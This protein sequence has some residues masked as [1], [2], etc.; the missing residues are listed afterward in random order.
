MYGENAAAEG[1][2]AFEAWLGEGSR[3]TRRAPGARRDRAV[4]VRLRPRGRPTRTSP[5]S[6]RCSRRPSRGM[7]A[8]RDAGPEVR[9]ASAWRCWP[10]CTRASSSWPTPCSTPA[11]RRSRWRSRPAAARARPRARGSGVRLDRDDAARRP[12]RSGRS[13]A[14]RAARMKRRSPCAARGGAGDRLQHLPDLE[15][16]RAVR[17]AGP[18]QPGRRQAAPGRRAAARDHGA[19]RGR[20]ARRGRLRPGPGHA[21]RRE[22]RRR[23]GGDSRGATGGQ[24][25]RLHRA[26]RSATGW[27]SMPPRRSCSPRRPA[28]TPSSSTRPTTFA[29]CAQPRVLL[30][31]LHRADVHDPQNL[32][33][34]RAASHRPEP[35]SVRRA[36]RRARR[37]ARRAA[38][39]GRQGGRA[40]GGRL[41]TT[42]WSTGS[43]RRRRTAG[44]CSHSGASPTPH[45]PAPRYALR[46][47]SG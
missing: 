43:R 30:R 38:R 18:R 16:V 37:R 17:V 8:W 28:S 2:A 5:T 35:K 36:G 41:S 27:S 47:S 32:F 11:G 19:G 4:A 34:P 10:A 33:R 13:P 44:S 45:S 1:K 20:G 42:A 23:A 26:A 25:H 14:R 40:A 3:S 46:L 15:L 12:R 22:T 6:T 9:P 7:R 21:R 29:A 31:A 24:A 39:R